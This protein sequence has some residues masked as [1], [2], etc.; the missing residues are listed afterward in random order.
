[1][2]F[3]D[4]DR[5]SWEENGR[6]Y[7]TCLIPVTGLSGAED[8]VDT[9]EVLERLGDFLDRIERP[10]RG[11]IVVYPAVQY[12]AGTAESEYINDI[13]RN[14][15]SSY[16]QYTVVV[17]A[18]ISLSSTDIYESDLVLSMTAFEH[19]TKSELNLEIG[20]R[21]QEMWQS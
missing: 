6:Y 12:R 13:C 14:V 5:Q 4:F 21:I 9:I 18:D 2:K 15:K 19:V 8:P 3:S 20:R 11:R 7:D 1:M 16:F 10:Y 17:S